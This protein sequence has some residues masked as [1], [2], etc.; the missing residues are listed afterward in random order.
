MKK[1]Y[2]KQ[3]LSSVL[4]A[5]PLLLFLA[6]VTGCDKED[7]EAPETLEVSNLNPVVKA[8][9]SSVSVDVSS[10]TTWKVGT[11]EADWLTVENTAGTGDG[12]IL[13]SCDENEAVQA[14]ATEFFVV[15]VKDGVYHKVK[16]TQLSSDPFITLEE[17][18]IEAGSRPRNHEIKLNSNIPAEAITVEIV[19]EKEES[20]D[21][22]VG[23]SVEAGTFKFQTAL[24]TTDEERVANIILSYE[25][26]ESEDTEV[27][28]KITVTQMAAGN[29][30]P[31]EMKDFDYVKGLPLGGIDENIAVEGNIVSTGSSGNFR[32]NTY[33]IQD[34]NS[35]A[36]AFES[37][38]NLIFDKYDKVQL[39]LDGSEIGTFED[40]GTEYRIIRGISTAS[41]LAQEADA[42]FAPQPVHIGDLT[43]DHLLAV[44]TL[45]D[46]EFAVPHGG[47]TNFHEYYVT[48]SYA[49]YAT[50]HY[51]API[52]DIEGNDMYLIT[53]REVE[54]RRNS[55][56]GGS[57]T[58]TGVVVK[59]TNSAYGNLGEFSIRHLEE[60]DI[61]I[62]TDP[63]N[64]FSEILVEWE[65]AWVSGEFADGVDNLPPTTGPSTATLQKDNSAGFHF[66]SAPANGVFLIDKY[67]GD[68]PGSNTIISRSS[69]N[70]N[71][72][73]SGRYWVM[74]NVSTTGITSSL[75]LQFEANSSTGNGPRDFIVEYS[76]DGENWNQIAS[77]QLTGQIAPNQSEHVVAGYKMYTYKLPDVLLNKPNIKI[78]LMNI[79][80]TSVNGGSTA[81]PGGTSRLGYFSIKYHK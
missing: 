9:G 56:P 5:V 65:K 41:I 40:C 57:G 11:I 55:V 64:G 67:R 50:K 13:L 68:K 26:T 30:G 80:S 16:L 18:E 81:I 36:I 61:A 69:Y 51:P 7:I 77:Y 75:S 21:W 24:N 23:I 14:R 48:Q 1:K 20:S 78:R 25:D 45:Q 53:N 10:N 29:D 17:N 32:N 37:A 71:S 12:Q 31:P 15:T 59:I 38:D 39:L 8:D 43:E 46:V 2:Y 3:V 6:V 19:Y 58:I 35:R 52:R 34:E 62:D 49:D 4:W 27:W 33:I 54:Y 73:G 47:Y 44:V 72:W 60:P 63:A 70:V 79:N 28:D 42:G 22:V 74:D 66:S 76:L